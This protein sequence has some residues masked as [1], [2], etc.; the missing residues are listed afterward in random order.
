MVRSAAVSLAL[1]LASGSVLFA[2]SEG[3]IIRGTINIAFANAS[4]IVVLTDSMQTYRDQTGEHQLK[5]P[6]QKLFRLD[7][8]TVCTIAGF[9]SQSFPTAPTF[10]T[11]MAGIL[12]TFKD[13]LSQHPVPQFA[14]KL[15]AL[16]YIVGFYLSAAADINDFVPAQDRSG[17]QYTLELILAGYDADGAPKLGTVVMT[18][19]VEVA[20]AG[21]RFW[22]PNVVTQVTPVKPEFAYI[23]HG[24]PDVASKILGTPQEFLDNPAVVRYAQSAKNDR[25]ESLTVSDMEA[26]AKFIAVES[27]K[28]HPEVG[29]ADQI[30]VLA[31]GGV[32]LD[33]PT[34]PEPKRQMN[35]AVV[36]NSRIEGTFPFYF[37]P[38]SHPPLFLWIG[39]TFDGLRTPGLVLDGQFF[40]GCKV[41]NSVVRYDG[42]F[43]GLD[44]SDEIID[45]WL[46]PG[47]HATSTTVSRSEL[48]RLKK[49]FGW[50]ADEPN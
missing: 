32:V 16:A 24:M 38:G 35:I 41:R 33:Q 40:Y 20:A 36:T 29:G 48:S 37:A 18:E 31:S 11:D 43:T 12:A 6:G 34:F 2:E 7:D 22:S 30:A 5:E 1:C 39:S 42:G 27:A 10:N 19:A 25:G 15:E 4:G 17:Q 46:V 21:D 45:S 8:R 14:A 49:S 44:A 13:Q 28:A 3:K 50:R 26:L 9:G 23:V 47:P